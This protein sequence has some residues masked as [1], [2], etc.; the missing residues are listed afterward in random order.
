MIFDS[1]TVNPLSPDD[2]T[3]IDFT[4]RLRLLRENG[5]TQCKGKDT[6]TEEIFSCYSRAAWDKIN[7]RGDTNR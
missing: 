2:F 5:A 1:V 4:E 3:Y 7:C 6:T